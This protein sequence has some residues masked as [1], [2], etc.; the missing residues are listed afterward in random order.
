MSQDTGKR[1]HLD[2][3]RQVVDLRE[4]EV[5]RLSA[6]MAD[7]QAVRQRYLGNLAR[8]EQLCNGSGPTGAQSSGAQSHSG[9]A[10]LSPVLS[11]N[12]GGY[13]QAVMKLADV[14]RVDLSLHESEMATTQRLMAQAVRRHEALDLVF[15]RRRAGVR[16]AQGV[17]ERKG[18]DELAVQVWLKG[19]K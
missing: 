15:E 7:K 1:R 2:T 19:H 5:D 4:R 3:L 9:Q 16:L 13:K 10:T 14:H 17:R 6:D 12:C 18:Q 11:L 8:L